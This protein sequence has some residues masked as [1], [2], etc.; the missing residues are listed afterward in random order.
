MNVYDIS[1]FGQPN[2]LEYAVDLDGV[3]LFLLC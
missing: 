2:V 1:E 3:L